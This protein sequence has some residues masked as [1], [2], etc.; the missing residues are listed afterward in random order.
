[1]SE[2]TLSIIINLISSLL[3]DGGRLGF[4]KLL[5]PQ[6]RKD[7]R[8]RK[9]LEDRLRSAADAFWQ[10][11][12]T[13]RFL[14]TDWFAVYL[15]HQQP[16]EKLCSYG[17][18]REALLGAGA[19]SQEAFIKTQAERVREYAGK[20]GYSFSAQDESTLC[21]FYRLLIQTIGEAV[22]AGISA[23]D[24]Y[25]IGVVCGKIGELRELGEGMSAKICMIYD[26]VSKETPD[27]V[28]DDISSEIPYEMPAPYL[29]RT[30]SWKEG[31]GSLEEIC[32]K[33]KRMILLGDAGG[34]K[35][36]ELGRLAA[37]YSR[38]PGLPIP[39]LVT[40]KEY[41][42]QS[43]EELAGDRK[44]PK[45]K[46]RRF[47]IIDGFDEIT[48]ECKNNFLK[49]LSWYCRKYPEAQFLIS[50]RSNFYREG[51]LGDEFTA[52]W[53]NPLEEG[54][55]RLFAEEQ[56]I[57][58]QDFTQ[59]VCENGLS[60]L[61][62]VPFY[63]LELCEL[64]KKSG[65][66]PKRN[67][68]MKQLINR[69]F[70]QDLD[71]FR[72]TENEDL[73]EKREQ[74]FLLLRKLAVSMHCM[75]CGSLEDRDYQ[76]LVEDVKQRELLKY[77]GIWKKIQTRW[78]F[79]HNNFREYLA[80]E[81][82]AELSMEQIVDMVTARHPEWGIC[83]SW[84]HVLSYLI[85][86]Y[87][88]ELERWV[89]EQDFTVF[90]KFDQER[91]SR[92]IRTDIFIGEMESLKSRDCWVTS[93]N[94]RLYELAEFGQSYET[95]SYLLKEIKCP[96][97]VISQG[98]AIYITGSLTCL[99]GREEEVRE[100][101][102]QVCLAEETRE[103]E[104][105]Y[106]IKGL[107]NHS[108][109]DEKTRRALMERFSGTESSYIRYGMYC[110]IGSC[111][112]ENEYVDFLIEGLKY[113]EGRL[114]EGR[115]G[116]ESFELCRLLKLVSEPEAVLKLVKYFSE[117]TQ[118][119]H[120]FKI[121]EIAEHLMLCAAEAFQGETE[122]NP[123]WI[124]MT[125]WVKSLTEY[126]CHTMVSLALEYFKKTDTR[127]EHLMYA[128]KQLER[129]ER[130]WWQLRQ[131]FDEETEELVVKG[132]RQNEISDLQVKFCLDIMSVR[133]PHYQPLARMY[134]ARTGMEISI[135]E[136]V[137]YEA[138]RNQGERRYLEALSQQREYLKLVDELMAAGVEADW[139][140]EEVQK[141]PY[142]KL[143]KRTDLEAVKM[144][145]MRGPAGE[146]IGQWK[147]ELEGENWE[148]YTSCYLLFWL[149]GH[150][151][152]E[153]PETVRLWAADY[154]GRYID[155]TDIKGAVEWKND[156]EGY[157]KDLRAEKILCFAR[158][159]SLP[160]KKEKAK[161][162]LFW[163]GS[164]ERGGRKSVLDKYL[165]EEEIRQQVIWNLQHEDLKG[166][167]L[168]GHISYCTEHEIQD[169]AGNIIKIAKDSQRTDWIRREAVEYACK[170]LEPSQICRE[171]LPVLE[172][173]LFIQ[174]AQKLILSEDLSENLSENSSEMKLLADMVWGFGKANENQKRRC[175][176][177]LIRM[178]DRRG[179]KN[180]IEDLEG[181]GAVFA[182]LGYLDPI[183]AVSQIR[184]EALLD[185]V[186]RLFDMVMEHGFKDRE[187]DGLASS[188]LKAFRGIGC[189]CRESYEKVM[190]ILE[191]RLEQWK[192]QGGNFR[193][194]TMIYHWIDEIRWDYRQK[195]QVK[196][197]LAEVKRRI[198][199][200]N[201]LN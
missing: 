9:E 35:T 187:F 201:L 99:F 133:S 171:I 80:A 117:H 126:G 103:H 65:I 130:R 74:L 37:V 17:L 178:Q 195:V 27:E 159:F 161:E 157:Y 100:T 135:P 78:Q 142:E 197:E 166:E 109:A 147:M 193:K 10:R 172:G 71:K 95:L 20:Y 160:M 105:C 106:A 110:L 22:G 124:A 196:W 7:K 72:M 43:I 29:P 15:E 89:L 81:Y 156:A 141:F 47:F 98:N 4:E 50:S 134:S 42:N 145:F 67:D 11:H 163:C 173:E 165:T 101:L 51:L 153:I 170:I 191:K 119:H 84:H 19:V 59:K 129:G 68:L 93:R 88:K 75:D 54:E 31:S 136:F 14:D 192:S 190:A 85:P 56:E 57:D 121:E 168:N 188:L 194:E 77:S 91:L 132:Y 138:L 96:E 24:S 127:M 5:P 143:E 189:E 158:H 64:Y 2:N 39:V 87:G 52:A 45:D 86:M 25:G 53:L 33:N 174:T 60:D 83:E 199:G 175:D 61:L 70:F 184:T 181:E 76:R 112:L 111:H 128:L 176:A 97:H 108:L 167:C 92:K 34:G 146:T 8:F 185:E 137:D 148:E 169:C 139:T 131:L 102:L 180:L 55:I 144:D 30:C 104:I 182:D 46:S 26:A 63:F 44:L 28:S 125:E 177:W 1:M 179:L 62:G 82:M 49:H 41:M 122:N 107:V 200:E 113:T 36:T 120:I 69:K 140:E 12:E 48:G 152:N 94:Y 90:L 183:Q 18:G 164:W 21:D 58:W 32:R 3:Y 114:H 66:L 154:Y 155:K 79:V 38:N 73:D 151:E 149:Y 6:L 116:N 115:L 150:R 123:L 16:V 118:V 23:E 198:F 186:E 40:L 162:L 13:E